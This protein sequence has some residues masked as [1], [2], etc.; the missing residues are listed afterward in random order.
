MAAATP[1]SAGTIGISG[2]TLIFGV[3][4]A[5]QLT[6]TGSTSDTELFL[7]GATFDLVT[8]GCFANGTNAVRCALAG[9]TGLTIVGSD[10]DDIVDLSHVGNLNAF[11]A[12]KDGADIILGGGGHD[13]LSGGGGDDVIFGGVGDVLFGG[14][15][16]NIVFDGG[17]RIGNPNDTPA[18]PVPLQ[19]VPEPGTMLLVGLGLTASAIGKRWRKEKRGA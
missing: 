6:L 17:G 11:V 13:V 4:A 1:A 5:E 12:A 8:P 19:P 7:F 15:G 14:R 3:D 18:D 9:F 16:A 10:L 2:T